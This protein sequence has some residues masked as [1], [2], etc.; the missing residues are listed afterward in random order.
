MRNSGNYLAP[1]GLLDK[2][3]IPT[4]VLRGILTNPLLVLPVIV[5]A[6]LLTEALFEYACHCIR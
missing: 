2:V 3:R 4:L 1:G 6:V 5:L